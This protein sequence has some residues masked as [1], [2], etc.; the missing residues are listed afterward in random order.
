M[1]HSPLSQMVTSSWKSW[2][3]WHA[4]TQTTPT[5]AS[6]GLTPT[7][8]LW[9]GHFERNKLADDFSRPKLRPACLMLL[10]CSVCIFLS[11][12]A[13]LGEDFPHW[14]VV[15]PDRSGWCWGCKS[16]FPS[17]KLTHQIHGSSNGAD[18]FHVFIKWNPEKTTNKHTLAHGIIQNENQIKKQL[19]CVGKKLL[20]CKIST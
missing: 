7:I 4:K 14:P 20:I 15:P 16:L 5:S 9:Y 19:V 6:S 11:A 18:L 10:E 3:R 8:S 13:L 1:Y 2:R 12:G 17:H